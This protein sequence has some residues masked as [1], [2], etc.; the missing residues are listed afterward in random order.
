MDRNYHSKYKTGQKLSQSK[1]KWTE[2]NTVNTKIGR[3][4]ITVITALYAS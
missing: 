4:E 1:L 3:N 2:I